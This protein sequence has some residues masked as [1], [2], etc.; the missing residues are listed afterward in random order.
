[1]SH[2][3]KTLRALRKRSN[4]SRYNLAGFSGVSETYIL[5]LETGER[6]NPS[7]DVVLMIALALVRTSTNIEIWDIDDLLFSANYA[8]LRRRGLP[9]DETR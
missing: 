6:S 8:P 2:F 4:K 9:F 5:R 3:G 7:R 1:M